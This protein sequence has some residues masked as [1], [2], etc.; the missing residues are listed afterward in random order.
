[1]WMCY[2]RGDVRW[3]RYSHYNG[4]ESLNMG[5][6]S[7]RWGRDVGAAIERYEVGCG[8]SGGHCIPANMPRGR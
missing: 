5:G 7:C 8:Y 6:K 2:R 1:M 3:E 4:S